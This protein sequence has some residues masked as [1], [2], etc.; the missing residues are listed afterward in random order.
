M[1]KLVEVKALRQSIRNLFS[2]LQSL[3]PQGSYDEFSKEELIMIATGLD[4]VMPL[5]EEIENKVAVLNTKMERIENDFASIE[6]NM[7]TSLSEK[8]DVNHTHDDM[9]DAINNKSDMR[10]THDDR[11]YTESEVDTKLSTKSDTS[12]SHTPASIGAANSSHTHNKSQITDFPTIPSVGNGTVT[13]KQNGT[14]K[15]TFTMNQSGNTTVELTDNNTTYAA[16]STN[17]KANGTAAVG[18]SAKYA[19]EDH[20]HPVQTSVSGNAGTATKLAT[21][22]KIGNASFD[23]SANITVAGIG[24][25]A[26]SHTH[27]DRYYTE[28]EIN[29]KIQALQNTINNTRLYRIE[30]INNIGSDLLGY[31]IEPNA[32][33]RGETQTCKI[34][35]KPGHGTIVPRV[36]YTYDDGRVVDNKLDPVSSSST[37]VEY[38]MPLNADGAFIWL[39]R[40]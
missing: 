32:V 5:I 28:S 15:G 33:R 35:Y 4:E 30:V 14:T 16:A 29:T 37:A 1:D 24:A 22:R 19:R 25:A 11:Y 23:G 10:H 26:S 40:S 7:T 6:T 18:T 2:R 8:A 21:A 12:H 36:K 38:S 3:V 31:T 17:P 34:L 9:V 39:N 13:I 20:V 27:D